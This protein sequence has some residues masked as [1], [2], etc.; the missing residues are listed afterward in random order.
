[1][2]DFH[3]P[4]LQFFLWENR[5]ADA[6]SANTEKESVIFQFRVW[7]IVRILVQELVQEPISKNGFFCPVFARQSKT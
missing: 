6:G 5:K 1:V 4:Q 2:W 3:S 7:E